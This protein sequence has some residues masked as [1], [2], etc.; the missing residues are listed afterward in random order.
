MTW[1]DDLTLDTVIIHTLHGGPSYK[2]VKRA[3]YDDGLVLDDVVNLDIDPLIVE[4]GSS[5]FPRDQIH[6]VQIVEGS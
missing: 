5:F 4:A 2:G 1:L 6:R 3:V